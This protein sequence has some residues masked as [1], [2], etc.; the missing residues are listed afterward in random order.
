MGILSP[1]SSLA[2]FWGHFLQSPVIAQSDVPICSRQTMNLSVLVRIFSLAALLALLSASARDAVPPHLMLHQGGQLGAAK[3]YGK[4]LEVYAKLTALRPTSPVP[5]ILMGDI[6][7][8]QGRW[9]ESHHEFALAQQL[10]PASPQALSG[11]AQVARKRNET[12]TAIQ[13]WSQALALEPCNTGARCGLAHVYAELSRFDLAEQHLRRAILCDHHDQ[14]AQYLLG[15]ITASHS[16]PQAIEH[17]EIAAKGDDPRLATNAREMLHLLADRS[18]AADEAYAAAR[19]AQAFLRYDLPG[20][21]IGQLTL[22]LGADPTNSTAR[23]YLGYAFLTLGES[24]LALQQLR[25][26]THRDSKN[27]LGYYVLGLLH[28]SEGYLSTALWDFK[29]SLELDPSNAAV[30]AEMA[31]TYQRRSDYR[32][33]EEWYRAAVTVAPTEPGFHLLLA[34]FYV[35]V[36]PRPEAGLAAAKEAAVLAPQDPMARDLLGW[37]H[38]LAGDLHG[39][40]E[41]LQEALSLDP[42]FARAYYHLGVVSSQLGDLDTAVWAYQRAT[43]LDTTGQ[44]RAKAT[45]ELSVMR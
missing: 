40:K 41:A 4:A 31:D 14:E 5:H 15:L 20:L 1:R 2:R 19:L 35:D 13:L 32:A 33:A 7:A 37:A 30:Y 8:A 22:V 39:A 26:V 17:L 18:T 38:Y 10:D 29:R 23:A 21:A 45:R 11:L 3:E 12:G 44:F 43:D 28:R 34:Q 25:Q 42:E 24:E 6:Y 27:P 9:N 36:V 16:P